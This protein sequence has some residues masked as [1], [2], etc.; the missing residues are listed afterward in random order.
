MIKKERSLSPTLWAPYGDAIKLILTG[1][2]SESLTSKRK[3]IYMNMLAQ[4]MRDDEGKDR[5][6]YL[7]GVRTQEHCVN[8]QTKE[9]EVI[10]FIPDLLRY[11][12]NEEDIST[13]P[14]DLEYLNKLNRKVDDDIFTVNGVNKPEQEGFVRGKKHW[15][16]ICKK[17][18]IQNKLFRLKQTQQDNDTQELV[19]QVQMEQS[20]NM[21]LAKVETELMMIEKSDWIDSIKYESH[22]GWEPIARQFAINIH[23]EKPELSIDQISEVVREELKKAN[24]TGKG[25]RIP[26]AATI[27][28]HALAGIKSKK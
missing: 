8:V 21:D 25:R 9:V 2:T 13:K 26:S 16:L 22:N 1:A 12:L 24:I 5:K 27:K 14:V 18:E 15:M 20:L 23:R 10:Y 19:S 28:R 6:R 11:M 4:G 7:P 17:I 3:A